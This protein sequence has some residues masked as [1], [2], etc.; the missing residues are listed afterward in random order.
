VKAA[1]DTVDKDLVIKTDPAQGA[2]VDKGATVTLTVSTGPSVV[3]VPDVAGFTQSRAREEILAAGL[4]VGD[5]TFEDSPDVSKDDVIG[6]DPKAGSDA[7]PDDVINI[8]VSTGQVTV[9]DFTGKK[10]SDAKKALQALGL[11]VNSSEE[12]SDKPAGTVL[13]QTPKETKVDQGS[14]VTIVV[15][16]AQP[17][18]SPS[19]TT[20]SPSPSET[21][22]SPSPSDSAT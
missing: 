12:A 11:S 14:S 13:S 1:S 2:E 15:A 19:E 4:T 7:A 22:P 8:I 5:V 3:K 18:P 9:P 17:S 16:K 10:F 20:P 21:T 6:T